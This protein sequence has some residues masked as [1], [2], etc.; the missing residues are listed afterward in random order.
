MRVWSV[1]PTDAWPQLVLQGHTT[2]VTC[3]CRLPRHDALVS[4]SPEVG[5]TGT[6]M[7]VWGGL[8]P[9]SGQH[10]SPVVWRGVLGSMSAG[11]RTA[12]PDTL[13][14]L[15]S[16]A[17]WAPN[18][19]LGP[20]MWSPLHFMAFHHLRDAMMLAVDRPEVGLTHDARQLSPLDLAVVLRHRHAVEA[21]LR[22]RRRASLTQVGSLQVQDVLGLG[23]VYPDILVRHLDALLLKAP[24]NEAMLPARAV[25]LESTRLSTESLASPL[26]RYADCQA[27]VPHDDVDDA[28]PVPLAALAR[29]LPK[30]TL[31]TTTNSAVAAATRSWR[32]LRSTVERWQTDEVALGVQVLAVPG[33]LPGTAENADCEDGILSVRASHASGG[34]WE[35]HLR[36][37]LT[38]RGPSRLRFR[39]RH[40]FCETRR[41]RTCSRRARCRRC[42]STCGIEAGARASTATWYCT[43][44]S[45]GSSWRTA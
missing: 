4:C 11:A 39:A 17:P 13:R 8:D 42:C 33:L 24:H 29:R 43:V 41:W 19:E 34:E 16:R 27:V 20:C 9:S 23:R 10:A 32:M 2:S 6:E 18:D 26:V 35:W 30:G 40:R 15:A 3:L 28:E 7:N 12:V 38:T 44:H 21:A 22:V 14:S 45:W 31:A 37:I 5:N 1:T 36:W 25:L